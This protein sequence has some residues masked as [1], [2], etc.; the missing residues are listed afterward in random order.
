MCSLTKTSESDAA[1]TVTSRGNPTRRRSREIV[2]AS[3]NGE[4]I[5]TTKTYSIKSKASPPWMRLPAPATTAPVPILAVFLLTHFNVAMMAF[6]YHHQHPGVGKLHAYLV[7]WSILVFCVALPLYRIA[8]AEMR[9]FSMTTATATPWQLRF[10]PELVTVT[11]MLATLLFR[12]VVIAFYMLVASMVLMSFTIVVSSI[13]SLSM[14]SKDQTSSPSSS[15]YSMEEVP[16]QVVD[17]SSD[18][19]GADV[20]WGSKQH[21]RLQLPSQGRRRTMQPITMVV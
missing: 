18:G 2:V 16:V 12:Q 5:T 7:N 20:S 11:T 14:D 8:L 13:Q 6:G 1:V 15:K 10:L 19:I 3:E 17:E 9:T 21:Q 4:A